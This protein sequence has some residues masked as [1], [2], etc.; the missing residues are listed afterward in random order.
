MEADRGGWRPNRVAVRLACG[1]R[2]ATARSSA[3]RWGGGSRLIAADREGNKGEGWWT[4]PGRVSGGLH[5]V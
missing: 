1:Y 3:V 2:A 5:W 4:T